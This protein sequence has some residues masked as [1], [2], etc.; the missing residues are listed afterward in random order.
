MKSSD[1]CPTCN[2]PRRSRP[3]NHAYPFCSARCKLADLGNWL[4]GHYKLGGEPVTGDDMPSE[5]D[6]LN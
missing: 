2:G 6:K 4:G 5:P 3:E 1:A